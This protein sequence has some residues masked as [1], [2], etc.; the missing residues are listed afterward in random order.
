[1]KIETYKDAFKHMLA[2]E[3][4][5]I[6]NFVVGSSGLGKI[7]EVSTYTFDITVERFVEELTKLKDAAGI[8]DQEMYN[9]AVTKLLDKYDF[10]IKNN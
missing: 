8:L 10:N 4:S 1:M 3:D 7:K 5:K 6:F 2:L 9:Q